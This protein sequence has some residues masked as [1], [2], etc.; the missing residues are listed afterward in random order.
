LLS[1]SLWSILGEDHHRPR[2]RHGSLPLPGLQRADEREG[3]I[4]MPKG[5]EKPQNKDNQP[6]LSIKEKKKKKKEKAAAK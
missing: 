3:G 5:Q 4:V 6:K 1:R 2:R